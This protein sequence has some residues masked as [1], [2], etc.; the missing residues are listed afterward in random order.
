MDYSDPEKCRFGT[1]RAKH[2]LSPLPKHFDPDLFFYG[3]KTINHYTDLYG[4]FGIIEEGGFWLSDHRFL[5][6]MEEFENGRKLTISIL[7]K[8]VKKQRHHN[9]AEVLEKTIEEINLLNEKPYYLCSFSKKPDSLN[10]WR[11]YGKNGHGVSI[12]FHNT[13]NLPSSHF[14]MMPMLS[15]EKVVYDDRQKLINL[16][17]TIR[18]Y[19]FEFFKDIQYGNEIDLDDWPSA[20][21][22]SLSVQF[23]NFKNP[24]Y[25]SE[26]EIR[27]VSSKDS[28]KFFKEINHRISEDRIIPYISTAKIYDEEKRNNLP[29]KEIRVGPAANQDLTISSIKE[30]LNNK[31][32]SG[33]NVIKSKI[34]F[35]G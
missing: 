31:G 20:L 27:L 28:L 10:Q 18:R 15:V 24:E 23:I 26:E 9:F 2:N 11:A 29:I 19:R 12:T 22:S 6:D 32:Y 33:V 34:P 8:M 17:R 30:Y 25:S 7:S 5:N 21:S 35:R 4:L 1:L 13:Q 16:V 14:F 3:G